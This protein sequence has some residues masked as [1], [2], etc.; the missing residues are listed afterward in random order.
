MDV[1]GHRLR[2][3]DGGVGDVSEFHGLGSD[4]L[5][6]EF[7]LSSRV[8]FDVGVDRGLTDGRL[9]RPADVG[10]GRN[11]GLIALQRH[12]SRGFSVKNRGDGIAGAEVDPYSD[13]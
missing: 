12:Q 8:A 4:Q 7:N 13:P 11:H 6:A 5:G 1:G 10:G 3:E 2:N 9:E